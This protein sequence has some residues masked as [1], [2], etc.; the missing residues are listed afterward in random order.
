[1][2]L[3]SG[4]YHEDTFSIFIFFLSCATHSIDKP[5]KI[6]QKAIRIIIKYKV[7]KEAMPCYNKLV[8]DYQESG[9]GTQMLKGKLVISFEIDQIGKCTGLEVKKSDI[10][11][12]E[13]FEM[14]VR[15][16]MESAQFP[17]PPSGQ[18][19]T[20]AHRAAQGPALPSRM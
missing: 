7:L 2:N 9:K 16:A 5:E 1:M 11:S 4:V 10:M 12:P 13:V 3:F 14:C 20:N 17:I 15:P 18:V 6:D 8:K 19:A